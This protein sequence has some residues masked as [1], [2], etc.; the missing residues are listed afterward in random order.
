[1]EGPADVSTGPIADFS[2]VTG[3]NQIGTVG[4]RLEVNPAVAV[5]D[6]DG[7][8]VAGVPV[9]FAVTSGGG[10][11]LTPS[12]LTDSAGVASTPWTLGTTT[13]EEQR[14][15]AATVDTEAGKSFGVEFRATAVPGEPDTLRLV[16]G[17]GQLGTAGDELPLPLVVRVDDAHGNPVGG[18]EVDWFATGG[19]TLSASTTLTLGDG[20]ASV[21]WTLGPA[22]GPVYSATATLAS[23]TPVTFTA[24]GG[25]PSGWEMLEPMPVAVRAA[26]AAASDGRVYVVGGTAA[27]GRTNRLQIYDEAA[28]SWSFGPD[29][30]VAADWWSAAFVGGRMHLLGGVTNSVAASTQHWIYDPGTASWS[31]G[32]P[33]PN[34]ASGSAIVSTSGKIYLM[35]GIDGPG[36]YAAHNQIYDDATETWSAGAA[37]P[38]PR[39]TWAAGWLDDRVLAVGG[40]ASGNTTLDELLSYDPASDVWIRLRSLPVAREAHGAAAVGDSFCAFGGRGA[41]DSVECYLP[42]ADRWTSAAPMPTPLAEVAAVELDGSV[43]VLGGRTSGSSPTAQAARFVIND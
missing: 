8:G 42:A 12:V 32:P 28:A 36:A 3:T 39:I 29:A 37:V 21:R 25:V 24:E 26:A 5:T 33:L 38:G 17:D 31:A 15:L 13:S 16:S 43:Y 35:G 22:T 7:R 2:I 19:G 10:A 20:L 18:V 30:P 9:S 14:L 4:D 23:H 11:A 6:P 40:E 41:E 34:P 1:M 27:G